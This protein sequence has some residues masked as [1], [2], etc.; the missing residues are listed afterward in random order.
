MTILYRIHEQDYAS[1]STKSS[2]GLIAFDKCL[3]G[4]PL[5]F[6]LQTLS[7]SSLPTLSDSEKRYLSF[8]LFHHVFSVLSMWSTIAIFFANSLIFLFTCAIRFRENVLIFL[9]YSIVSFLSASECGVPSPF[10]LQTLSF[11]SLPTLSLPEKRYLS[12]NSG[13]S[14]FS[15]N[16]CPSFFPC[17]VHVEYHHHSLCKLSFCFHLHSPIPRKGIFFS[18]HVEHHAF[19]FDFFFKKSACPC[20]EPTPSNSVNFF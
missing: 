2:C 3:C 17:I 11:S 19:I 7:F 20:G 4:V 14:F 13:K 16:S 8:Y 18:P 12:C 10:S 15:F 1:A 9:L 5:P 6:S